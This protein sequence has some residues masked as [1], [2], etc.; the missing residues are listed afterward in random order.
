MDFLYH[1]IFGGIDKLRYLMCFLSPKQIDHMVTVLVNLSDSLSRKIF[2]SFLLMTVGLARSN[3]KDCVQQE[4]SLFSPKGQVTVN[5]FFLGHLKVYRQVVVQCFVD[6]HKTWWSLDALID[7][8]AHSHSFSFLDIGILS[9]HHNFDIFEIGLLESIKDQVA[10]RVA[11]VSF[12]IIFLLN[13]VIKCFEA[14]AACLFLQR[15]FPIAQTVNKLIKGFKAA[16][17]F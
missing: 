9:K 5:F 4:H 14:R 15:L 17:F 1:K 10:R 16:R 6:I 7:T 13:K 2:P 3:S 11:R 12:G 8:K